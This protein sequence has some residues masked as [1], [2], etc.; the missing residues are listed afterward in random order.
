MFIGHVAWFKYKKSRDETA[1]VNLFYGDIEHGLQ[2]RNTELDV[3]QNES[4]QKFYHG[5]IRLPVEFENN[6]E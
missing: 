3:Q 2:I 4:L 1:N 6:N 5:K